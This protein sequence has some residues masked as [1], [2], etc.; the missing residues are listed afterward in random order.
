M[1]KTIYF[2]NGPDMYYLKFVS[3]NITMSDI[4]FIKFEISTNQQIDNS[5]KFNHPFQYV[6]NVEHVDHIKNLLDDLTSIENVESLEG[7]VADNIVTKSLIELIM[8]EDNEL[9]KL[10]G[11]K[12]VGSYRAQ[13]IK[14]LFELKENV[15]I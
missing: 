7:I 10:S 12:Q 9:D 1:N 8:T 4:N 6:K 5:F 14:H 3:E 13:L 2:K 11:F 15:K